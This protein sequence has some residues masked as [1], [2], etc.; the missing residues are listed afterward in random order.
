LLPLPWKQK[1]GDLKTIL[2][3]FIKLC[4]NIYRRVWQL[5]GG[6]EK[7]KMAAIAMVTKVQ[8][9]RQIQNSSDLGKI[10]FPSRL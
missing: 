3:P 1:R 5:L 10:W 8:N 2:I 6:W 7:F 9:G 4:R